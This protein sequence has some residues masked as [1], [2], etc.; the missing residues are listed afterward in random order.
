VDVSGG[1]PGVEGQPRDDRGL[2]RSVEAVDVGGRIGLG[3]AE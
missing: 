3:V 1:D 2:G